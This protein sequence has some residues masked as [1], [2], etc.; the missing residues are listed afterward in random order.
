[1]YLEAEARPVSPTDGS[2][3]GLEDP[4]KFYAVQMGNDPHDVGIKQLAGHP[5]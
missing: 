4:Y 3:L 2:P 1:M 5:R